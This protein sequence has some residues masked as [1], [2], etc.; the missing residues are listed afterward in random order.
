MSRHLINVNFNTN[1]EG[2]GQLLFPEN[3]IQDEAK[4]VMVGRNRR[5][6]LSLCFLCLAA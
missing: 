2:T 4:N 6:D 1:A 3:V 5:T